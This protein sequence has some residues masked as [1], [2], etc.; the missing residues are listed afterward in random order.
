MQVSYSGPSDVREFNKSDLPDGALEKKTS[1]RK[2]EKVEVSNEFAKA[3]QAMPREAG[4]WTFYEEDDSTDANQEELD[5]GDADSTPQAGDSVEA[6][7]T[8]SGRR[9]G[10]ASTR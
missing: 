10:R 2:G 8:G 1:F 3:I 9:S 7:P 5:L 6:P 4:A